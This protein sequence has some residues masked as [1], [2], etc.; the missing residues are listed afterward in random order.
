MYRERRKQLRRRRRTTVVAAAVAVMAVVVGVPT[1][2]SADPVSDLVKGLTQ[3]LGLDGG[4]TGGGTTT[5]GG[6]ASPNAGVPPD[7][8]PP[9]HGTNPHGQGTD[10]IVDLTPS[11][12][13]PY[14]GTPDSNTEQ[15]IVGDSRGDQS[16]DGTYHGSI[17]LARVLGIPILQVQ[18]NPGETKEGPLDALQTGLL[19]QICSASG[20]QV[21]LTLLKMHSSSSTT[22]SENS[23]EA[24]GA[25]I[26]GAAGIN[27]DVL[28]SNGNIS[29][30]GT[31]QT[32]HGDSQVVNALVGTQAAGLGADS[33]E[34]SSDSTACN[35]GTQSVNQ[36]SHVLGF[37][38]V[39]AG[40]DIP[41]TS[42]GCENGTP[43]SQ[44]SLLG[45][46]GVLSGLGVASLVC[47]ADDT[48]GTQ[49]GAPYGVREGL[50]LGLLGQILPIRVA[51][52]GPESHAVAPPPT[53]TPPTTP[54]GGGGT[55]G[56][57]GKGG[58]NGGNGGGGNGGGSGGNGSAAGTAAPGN[59][60][61]AFTG[62][63]LLALALVG[64]ALILGGLA[65]TATAGRRHR[66]TI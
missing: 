50:T 19:D 42:E 62:A 23:F 16:S 40:L 24:V 55:K 45:L 41:I 47:N 7:Y 39:L 9:L 36:E 14:P 15:V 34:G 6:T 12:T 13:N 20:N 17:T 35:N 5:G 66:R 43:N 1:L 57:G 59:G 33:I 11:D 22:G 65:L 10:A 44:P 51:T 48:N 58:N 27:A 4:S 3:N 28:T 53:T 56:A 54:G 60:Q 38:G 29:S 49:T 52:A 61:L 31:C 2:A 46:S 18:S 37:K 30:D 63:D 21:C 8:T 32:A 64:G 26:G 25:H